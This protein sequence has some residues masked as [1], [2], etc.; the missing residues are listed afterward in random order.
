MYYIAKYNK[1]ISNLPVI[2]QIHNDKKQALDVA[3]QL[4]KDN[5]ENQYIVLST[6]NIFKAEITVTE[7]N[8]NSIKEK[9]Q[10][11]NS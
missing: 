5:V 2:I 10:D 1:G 9:E 4:T 7:L 8:I 11:D 3:K 6:S